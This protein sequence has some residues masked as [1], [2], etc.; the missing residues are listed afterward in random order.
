MSGKLTSFSIDGIRTL[1]NF[2]LELNGLT[3]LIGEN[4]SGKS[5][6]VEAFEIFR[7][8]QSENFW[9]ELN[10]I[11]GGPHLLFRDGKTARLG[12]ELLVDHL[13]R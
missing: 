5:S 8:F 6:V 12:V 7:R 9:S 10:K 4:G 13:V 11:H 3:V 2:K 1:K